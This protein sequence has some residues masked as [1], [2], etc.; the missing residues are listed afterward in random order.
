LS[1]GSCHLFPPSQREQ[2]VRMGNE[3]GT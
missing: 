2:A 3:P 1:L